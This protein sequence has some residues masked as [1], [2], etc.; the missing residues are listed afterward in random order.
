VTRLPARLLVDLILR[1][2]AAQG[3]FAT[4]LAHGDDHGGAILIHCCERGVAGPLFERDFD[5]RWTSIGPAPDAGPEALAAYAARR[6]AVDPDIWLIEL[7]I[8]DAPRF[9][10]NLNAAG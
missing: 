10:A 5:G 2:A 6:R 8:A 4:V 7:D 3:G 9:V 1:S